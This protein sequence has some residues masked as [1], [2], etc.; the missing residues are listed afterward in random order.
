[1]ILTFKNADLVAF[2]RI[3]KSFHICIRKQINFVDVVEKR[4]KK[5]HQVLIADIHNRQF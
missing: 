3:K 5:S 2:A 4:Y 1:M